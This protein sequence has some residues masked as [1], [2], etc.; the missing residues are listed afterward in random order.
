[1]GI[2]I[3]QTDR[4]NLIPID[5]NDSIWLYNLFTLLKDIS[6]LEG[7][8]LFCG[9]IID[10]KALISR[11]KTFED[12]NKGFLWSICVKDNPIGFILIYDINEEP[13]YAYGLFP[14]YRHQGYFHGIL[15][16]CKRFIDSL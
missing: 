3:L 11:F 6:S 12:R 14:A 10:T 7:L 8:N 13:F 2:K 16:R 15:D 5:L 4:C 1:M 9:S